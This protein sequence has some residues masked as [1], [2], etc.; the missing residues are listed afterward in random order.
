[1]VVFLIDT[2]VGLLKVN[3]KTAQWVPVMTN[4]M[5]LR[6]DAAT[7]TVGL[8]YPSQH[9]INQKNEEMEQKLNA[10]KEQYQRRPVVLTAVSPGKGKMIYAEFLPSSQSS[11]CM[12][13][14]L[15]VWTITNSA[16]FQLGIWHPASSCLGQG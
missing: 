4:S 2:L 10:L 14:C 9:Q 6:S 7:Q 8:Y 11:M 16:T 15:C 12:C 5:Q 1:M 13:E 3:G